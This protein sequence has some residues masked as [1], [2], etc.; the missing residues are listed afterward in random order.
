VSGRLGLCPRLASEVA[1]KYADDPWRHRPR[2]WR[3][4]TTAID[5]RASSALISGKLPGVGTAQLEVTAGSTPSSTPS[6]LPTR[7][8]HS[9]GDGRDRARY[10]VAASRPRSGS[11]RS[12]RPT[13]NAATFRKHTGGR[14]AADPDRHAPRT[15]V[16]DTE[17]LARHADPRTN[18]HCDR[19]RGT[20]TATA[21]TSPP[22][23]PLARE[24]ELADSAPWQD[25]APGASRTARRSPWRPASEYSHMAN[26]QIGVPTKAR[27][28]H[29]AWHVGSTARRN[30]PAIRKGVE[31]TRRG[32]KRRLVVEDEYWK[33]IL[34]GVGT[35]EACCEVGIT[36][37]TGYRWRNEAGGIPPARVAEE[38]RSS[39]YLSLLER[40]R[41][42]TLREQRSLAY[43]LLHAGWRE[44]LRSEC[45]RASCRTVGARGAVRRSAARAVGDMSV[46]IGWDEIDVE[47]CGLARS[48]SSLAHRRHA[49]S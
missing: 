6:S 23:T 16:R 3:P 46:N 8:A 24:G 38:T 19:A 45:I 21:S 10:S 25:S 4:S 35:V 18:E 36:R 15:P 42:A 14:Q 5:H 40:Q 34:A 32:R 31:M 33:L 7:G 28:V 27:A 17:L 37:K 2:A 22:L 44:H 30:T 20:S 11:M 13:K 43:S 49:R 39:R 29:R 9:P 41:I 48:T 47:V 12:H 26:L 1:S